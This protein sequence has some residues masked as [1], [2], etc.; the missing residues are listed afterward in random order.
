MTYHEDTPENQ[1]AD[2]GNS[3]RVGGQGL[4]QSG[5]DND[6]KLNTIYLLSSD[7]VCNDS[8][9]DL[10]NNSSARG[11]DFDGCVILA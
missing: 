4:D 8:K 2:D 9:S 1:E 3:R 5:Y 7:P 10:A 6:D 11:S